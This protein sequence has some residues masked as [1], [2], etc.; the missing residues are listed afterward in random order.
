MAQVIS[1]NPIPKRSRLLLRIVFLP[2]DRLCQA[3]AQITAK[4]I[5]AV[6]Y[7]DKRS[8]GLFSSFSPREEPVKKPPLPAIQLGQ[9]IPPK[10][11]K[12][13]KYSPF[14]PSPLL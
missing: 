5:I 6:L 14:L 2:I 8:Y 9:P 12:R 7:E 4:W 11:K 1:H 3:A 13:P 10:G